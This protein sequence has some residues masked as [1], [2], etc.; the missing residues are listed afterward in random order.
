MSNAFMQ[1]KGISTSRPAF[2]Q[3]K[4]NLFVDKAR[5]SFDPTNDSHTIDNGSS[6]INYDGS[7]VNPAPISQIDNNDEVYGR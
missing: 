4:N 3:S 5:Q 2:E 7:S 6:I 1:A